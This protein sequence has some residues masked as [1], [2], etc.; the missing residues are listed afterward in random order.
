MEA[1]YIPD[2]LTQVFSVISPQSLQLYSCREDWV[3]QL[4]ST[5]VPRSFPS[6]LWSHKPNT[7]HWQYN[8][9][10]LCGCTGP[11]T[12]TFSMTRV[13]FLNQFISCTFSFF[14]LTNGRRVNNMKKNVKK[15]PFQRILQGR[16]TSHTKLL[17][18]GPSQLLTGQHCIHDFCTL[19]VIRHWNKKKK[20]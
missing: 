12:M 14:F 13:L 2:L 7:R 4:I 11:L 6:S 18:A 9:T 8:W 20:K 19:N 16:T 15:H 1:P 17:F 10:H 3:T 5:V